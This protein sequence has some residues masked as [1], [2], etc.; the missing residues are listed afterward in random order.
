MAVSVIRTIASSLFRIVGSGTFCTSTLFGR[1]QQVAFIDYPFLHM[2]GMASRRS[3][4][5]CA[6]RRENV[7]LARECRRLCRMSVRRCRVGLHHLTDL[8]H[9][10]EGPELVI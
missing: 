8:H 4:V 10:L 1:I 5:L 7:S 2:Q 3:I 9:L 6:S